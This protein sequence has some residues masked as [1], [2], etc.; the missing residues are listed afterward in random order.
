[1]RVPIA[2][3]TQYEPELG[4]VDA[5]ASRS[6]KCDRG[7]DA[8]S[9]GQS[10]ERKL[11]RIEAYFRWSMTEPADT[12]GAPTPVPPAFFVTQSLAL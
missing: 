3:S 8:T 6:R 9:Q 12:F 1:M 2:A 10:S 5:Q 11:Q 4:P 7:D